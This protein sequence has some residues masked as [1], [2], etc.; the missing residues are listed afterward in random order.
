MGLGRSPRQVGSTPRLGHR[1]ARYR[2]GPDVRNH[3]TPPA[4]ADRQGPG[5]T[6]PRCRSRVASLGWGRARCAW[7]KHRVAWQEDPGDELPFAGTCSAGAHQP[8]YPSTNTQAH[9]HYDDYHTHPCTRQVA[10]L[11]CRA[12]CTPWVRSRQR[13]HPPPPLPDAPHSSRSVLRSPVPFDVAGRRNSPLPTP[14]G[15][16]ESPP[17]L[18]MGPGAGHPIYLTAAPALTMPAP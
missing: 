15:R 6:V 12:T 11:G 3:A 14:I 10:C 16:G 9:H 7:E 17:M 18:G 2:R 13:P 8:I 1:R 4:G 5:V